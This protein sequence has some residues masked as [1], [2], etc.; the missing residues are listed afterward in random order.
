M[1]AGAHPQEGWS[2]RRRVMATL[3]A[4]VVATTLAMAGTAATSEPQPL[5]SPFTGAS[6]DSAT[7]A[8]VSDPVSFDGG[9]NQVAAHV[10]ADAFWAQGYT[11]AGIDVAIIDTGVTPVA[12]LDAS[13]KIVNGPDLSFDSQADNLRYIDGNGHGTHL[14]GIIAGKDAGAVAST[15]NPGGFVG[16]APDARLVNVKVGNHAGAVD[17]S[18]VIAAIDWVVQHRNDNGLNIRVLSLAYGTDGS[19][20]YRNDPLTHAV[21][22]AWKA[23]IVV[24]VASG[25]D[26]NNHALRNPATDPYVIAVGASDSIDKGGRTDEVTSFSNC[27]NN[28]RHV[29]VVAPGASIVSLRTPGSVIDQ[30]NP[31][32]VVADRFFLGSGTSQAAAVTAGAAALLLDQRPELKPDQVKS[33]LMW[34]ATPL[35]GNSRCYGGGLIDLASVAA[36]LSHAT[37]QSYQA[38]RGDGTLEGARG[39][40]HL[41]LEGVPLVGEFDIFGQPWDPATWAP[42]SARHTSWTG[43]TW[44]GNEWAGLSWSGLSWSGLSW[45]GLS[46]SGLSW[47]GLSWSDM[48]WNGLSWSGLSWS[49]SAWSG[50]SW[51]GLSWSGLSWK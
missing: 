11:G 43:G 7:A 3:T 24:V 1:Y 14:A 41:T 47:S 28:R 17:V 16:I 20:D 48:T 23:G 42:Q 13:G 2:G 49:S 51:S 31:Q 35:K 26:G 25:N 36:S 50:L 18:Q 6:W 37:T 44:N 22:Q 29:D 9:V 15:S 33:M 39:S 38:S 4:F 40:Y 8:S 45:S 12:G 30:E 19:Q 5:P 27:G 10:G 21:E 32:A 46:W 34:T